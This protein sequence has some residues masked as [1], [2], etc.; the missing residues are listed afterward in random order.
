MKRISRHAASAIGV[1]LFLCAVAG[2]VA[3]IWYEMTMLQ[4]T[5]EKM[6]AGYVSIGAVTCLLVLGFPYV[7]HESGHLLFGLCAGLRIGRVRVGWLCVGRDGLKFSKGRPAGETQ[8][9]LRKVRGAHVRL[10]AATLGGPLFGLMY[11]VIFLLLWGLLPPHPALFFFALCAPSVLAEALSELLPAEFL[12]GKTDGLVLA[13]LIGKTGE[14]EIAIR[15]MKVQSLLT[16]VTLAE[17]PRGLLF[18]V[19]V[20][21]EDSPVFSELLKLQ[22]EYLSASG[23]ISGAER[24]DARLR[25]IS[26]ESGTVSEELS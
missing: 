6:T 8:F 7:V 12:S 10:F 3:M 16:D 26:E 13:E 20:I 15:V 21:R 2:T 19:P 11:G 1:V 17:I 24:I 4:T 5:E 18:D 25:S 23:D 22:K 9:A 14:T